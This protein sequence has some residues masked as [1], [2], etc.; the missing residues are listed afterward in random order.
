MKAIDRRAA[1][2][3]F[4]G[5]SGVTITGTWSRLEAKGRELQVEWRVTEE[6]AKTISNT[7]DVKKVDTY[8]QRN[9]ILTG[10]VILV[11]TT[12]V[13]KI[14]EAIGDIY[15]RFKS[16][17]GVIIDIRSKPVVISTSNRVAPGYA[18]IISDNGVKTIQ[19]GGSQPLKGD[20]LKGLL[21]VLMAAARKT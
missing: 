5:M 9:P 7:L 15:F 8:D 10:A 13:P 3:L 1:L 17:G 14:A 12:L 19:V 6:Q 2:T 4:A 11:G 18:L 20:D 21:D 16:S